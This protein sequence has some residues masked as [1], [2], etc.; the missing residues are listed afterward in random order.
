MKSEFSDLSVEYSDL[1][2]FPDLITELNNAI[3]SYSSSVR[4]I[5]VGMCSWLLDY[6]CI[7]S[8]HM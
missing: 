6:Y 2:S 8:V 7:C 4:N 3:G 1:K 5:K